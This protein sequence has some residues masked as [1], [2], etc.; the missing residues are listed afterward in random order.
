VLLRPPFPAQAITRL[1]IAAATA[2]RR[3]VIQQTGLVPEIKWPNDLL[4]GGRKFA[5]ILTEMTA[6]LDTVRFAVLGVG[7]DVNQ[8][9][10]DFPADLRPVATSLRLMAGRVVDRAALAAALLVELDRDYARISSGRFEAVADEWEGSCTTLG[11]QVLIQVGDR[12]IRGRAEALD[13]D[14]LLLLRNE[15]GHL[16]RILSG[17]LAVQ[18]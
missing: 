10:A 1:T 18:A 15:H 6:E 13:E 4:L 14:G 5:G 17:H 7:V 9:A 16:E 11:K 2:L 8:T 12:R 3:A